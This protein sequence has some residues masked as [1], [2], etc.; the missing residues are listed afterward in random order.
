MIF[1]F[2]KNLHHQVAKIHQKRY[3]TKDTLALSLATTPK[4]PSA[5]V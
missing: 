4:V 5:Y 2:K 1:F 3:A